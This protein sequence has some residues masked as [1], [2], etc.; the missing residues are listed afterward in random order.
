ELPGVTRDLVTAE[1][2]W[3]GLRYLACDTGG[4]GSESEDPLQDLV[5]ERAWEIVSRADV[6][7]F[8]TDVRA[9]IS[10]GEMELRRALMKARKPLVLVVNKVDGEKLEAQAAEF[11]SL[12]IEPAVLISALSGRAF[13][14]FLDAINA[15]IGIE[16]HPLAQAGSSEKTESDEEQP[17]I[18]LIVLGKQNVGKSSLVNALLAEDKVMVSELPGTTRD[19]ISGIFA[20]QERT[21]ELTDTAGLQKLSRMDDVDYYSFTRMDMAT[22]TG[23]IC[24][25]VLDAERGVEEMDKRVA[26]RIEE[27]GRGVVIVVNKWDL[28]ADE[29]AARQSYAAYVHRK[30]AK[31]TWAPVIFTSAVEATGLEELLDAVLLAHEN[32]DRVVD[33]KAL[34]QVVDEE[35][36][37]YPPPVVKNR[38]LLLHDVYQVRT[39]PPTFVVEVNDARLA[40]TAY[41]NFLENTLRKYF[42]L[43]GTHVR[44]FLRGAGS[45]QQTGASRSGRTRSKG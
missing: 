15:T 44:L 32:F 1:V 2:E 39:R 38:N 3:D 18:R 35:T 22:R 36:T 20:Y 37:L 33:A 30:L 7:V 45:S 5:A 11:Y 28:L 25:L 27:Y 9:G 31:L 16:G 13:D 42:P 41:R 23:E 17:D 19:A 34:R 29:E 26:R 10:E 6:V 4:I 40:R 12:G 14:E 24:L 8:V 21:F 43:E